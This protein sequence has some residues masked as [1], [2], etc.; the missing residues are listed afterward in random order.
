MIGR[1]LAHYSIIEKVGEGGM[2]AVYKARDERLDR[3][4]A[5]KILPAD[6]MSDPERRRRFTQEAKS[7][8]ALNHPNIVTIYDIGEADGVHFIAMEYV[9][10]RTLDGLIGRRGL[11][12]KDA[13]S[14]AVQI[15]DG[16]GK[17]HA[18]GIVHRDLKPSN[19]MVTSDGL[20]K[21]LDFGLAK[22]L[23]KTDP[24]LDIG[25]TMTMGRTPATEEGVIL[26]TVAYMSPE[27]AAG[28][29]V[30]ARSDIF[31]FGSVLYEMLTGRRA[32][33]GET[34]ASTLAAVITQDPAAPNEAATPLPA[35]VARVVMRCLRKDPQR[36]W[37]N[38]ADLKVALQDLK[39]ESESGLL[40]A[41]ETPAPPKRR[42]RLVPVLSGAAVLA[43][44]AIFAL[45]TL[46]P[47]PAPTM[48]QPDRMTFEEGLTFWPAVSSDGSMIAYSSDRDGDMDIYVRPLSG[49]QSIRRTQ[50]PAPD[51]YACFS[52]DGSKI[53][54][55]SERDGG[56]LYVMEALGGPERRIADGGRLP[57]FS[58]DGSTIVYLVASALKRQAKL[59]LV[60]ADGG[61]PR[62]FQPEFIVV[63]R[64]ASYSSPLWSA[65]GK[66]I[67]FDGMRPGDTTS[68][69]WWLAPVDGGPA[70]RI[71]LPDF[72]Y[73]YVR[74]V[75]AWW[76]NDIYYS[77]GSTVGGM[78][79]FRIPLST[80]SHPEAGLP[81]LVTSPAGMQYGASISSDGRIVFC[82]MS[83]KINVW[84]VA[85][86]S[87]D[88]TAAAPPERVT[89]D[90]LGKIDLSVS[91]DGSK[92]AWTSY[93][94]QQTEI[95]IRDIATGREESIVCSNNT[96]GVVPRLSPDGSRLAYSDVVDGKRVA[97][98]AE[99]GATPRPITGSGTII[100]FFKKTGEVL[101][102]SGNRLDRQDLAGNGLGAVLDTTGQ[103]EL[104][105][106]VLSP[107]NRWVA[108]TLALPDG[109]AAL[110][111]APIGGLPAA[112]ATWTKLD[113]DRNFIGS[114]AWSGDGK[115]LYYGSN[116]DG[117][118]CVW[119][120]RI[121]GDGKPLGQP[122]AAF[123]DHTPPDTN[124][125]G[126]CW[127]RAAPDRLYLLLSEFK[128]DLWSLKLPR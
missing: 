81:Q 99:I 12:L 108:F 121:G 89:S 61:T 74:V 33:E 80:G 35:E 52:P 120:Q 59:F 38:M 42:S 9:E 128:G 43:A 116:R 69:G 64:G 95:R 119:A 110:Y 32:F 87:D 82:T 51:W 53:V 14:V 11:P 90:S 96:I 111:L 40:S 85:L 56:G 118:L 106:A 66:L 78:S 49:Q 8:S 125:Y 39:E 30:D 122:F 7:A 48:P 27:Q 41:A 19:I 36:R 3:F 44:A 55:R 10:G 18:A 57:S 25:A 124:L 24:S 107:S 31:S 62:P 4:V 112:V 70:L 84:S 88:G 105:D 2:G 73:H 101:A 126:V 5:L 22:L 16:L 15:A 117:F 100:D 37:Q 86:K 127:V 123:H 102:K 29:P 114:P 83:P 76:N 17:A 58:P 54:F 71:K 92:L 91:A 23:E 13:L 93:N 47:S 28:K 104:F 45:L 113:E 68:L 63:S 1:S 79:L 98:I 21:V 65:D 26:G 72:G 75:S 20:V 34:K 97:Y 115:T 67:L 103:G 50:H 60:P 46:K 6:K 109:K 77:E 94:L